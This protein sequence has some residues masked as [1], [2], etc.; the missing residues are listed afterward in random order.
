MENCTIYSH[1]LA[2]EKVVQIV[3]SHL[4]KA[5]I[6]YNDGGPQKSLVATTK[7]GFFGKTKTLK[8]NYRERKNPSYKLDEIECGLTQ[9]LT[10]MVNFIQS[11][12]TQNEDVKNKLLY[13]VMSANCEIPFIAEPEITSEFESVLR[14]IVQE[15]DAIVFA[16]PNRIF[17]TSSGKHFT[18][19]HL[20]LVLDT[21]GRCTVEDL[22]VNVD[23]KYH[24][25]PKEHYTEE[26]LSRKKASESFLEAYAIKTNEN[27]PCILSSSDVVLRTEK[28][29]VD[30]AY[31]LLI[32]AVKGEGVEQEHLVTT[33]A[34]KNI[35]SLSPKEKHIYQ[36][37]TLDDQER[38]YATWRYESLYTVLWALGIIDGLIYPNQICD[39]QA[40]VGKI[41]QTSRTDFEGSVKL[42]NKAEILDELD[43]TYRMNWACVDARIKGE[44]VSG[45]ILPSV[46]YER[47]YA[48]NWI[49]SHQNQ[50][51]DDVL[52]NT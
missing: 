25:E 50:D 47:H 19:K 44:E 26:Q 52:T 28:D 11:L 36:A 7:G 18:D 39:V 46:V 15:L 9:N 42:R 34:A 49:I 29:M 51:W 24:D 10:G 17:N 22:D 4:P 33:V 31:A 41:F 14:D 40:I 12:P 30:R 27:L 20:Q 45:S 2:F 8:I 5:K 35:E 23:A 43:K 32:T 6:E 13:K 1:K 48:L 3:K 38:G 16:T 37:E 21:S